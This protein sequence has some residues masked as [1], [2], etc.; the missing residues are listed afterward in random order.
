MADIISSLFLIAKIQASLHIFEISA[1]ENPND[2]LANNSES[3]LRFLYAIF[4]K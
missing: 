4:D 1:P 3:I 2:C